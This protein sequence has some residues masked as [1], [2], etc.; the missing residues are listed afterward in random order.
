MIDNVRCM[1]YDI[2]HIVDNIRYIVCD[3]PEYNLQ[4]LRY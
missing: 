1:I 4:Y 3:F 2:Y